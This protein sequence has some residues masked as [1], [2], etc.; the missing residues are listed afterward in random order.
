MR[1][2][3]MCCGITEKVITKISYDTRTF[4]TRPIWGRVK[5]CSS[6]YALLPVF[7]L[8]LIPPPIQGAE[9]RLESKETGTEVAISE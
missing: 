4:L 3:K 5:C 9:R 6:R 1:E 2:A 7:F 8:I